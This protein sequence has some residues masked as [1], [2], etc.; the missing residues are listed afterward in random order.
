M[1][2]KWWG[3]FRHWWRIFHRTRWNDLIGQ[4]KWHIRSENLLLF[5]HL[6]MYNS[7]SEVLFALRSSQSFERIEWLK[8]AKPMVFYS[9][10]WI[11]QTIWIIQRLRTQLEFIELEQR[12]TF[13]KIR[14]A[15]IFYIGMFDSLEA[16]GC[17]LS[18][19]EYPANEGRHSE[20]E[21]EII[22]NLMPDTPFHQLG[23]R[24][25]GWLGC[26]AR[27]TSP[28]NLHPTNASCNHQVSLV[29]L[30]A[31][32]RAIAAEN[33]GKKSTVIRKHTLNE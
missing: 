32:R 10:L 5:N 4:I 16:L 27:G 23:C 29:K 17:S 26:K 15:E 25:I 28:I 33:A 21:L 14:D 13:T 3:R 24:N 7:D 6:N 1:S 2:S 18:D 12:K 8:V 9:H 31:W 30:V 22:R 20:A 19:Y 11:A